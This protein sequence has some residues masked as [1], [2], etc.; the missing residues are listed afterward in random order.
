MKSKTYNIVEEMKANGLTI[1]EA[2][3]VVMVVEEVSLKRAK[4]LVT[5]HP[6]WSDTVKANEALHDTLESIVS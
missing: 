2:M 4:V 1:I 5:A 3:K 6:A